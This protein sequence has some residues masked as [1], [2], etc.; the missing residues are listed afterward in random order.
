MKQRRATVILVKSDPC[1]FSAQ[2]REWIERRIAERERRA[3]SLAIAALRALR[4]VCLAIAAELKDVDG[5]NG[6]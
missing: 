3:E 6:P 4:R 5:H 1:P 2:E